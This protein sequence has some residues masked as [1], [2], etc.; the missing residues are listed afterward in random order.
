M[1]KSERRQRDF[2][3]Q[4]GFDLSNGFYQ[5]D[6]DWWAAKEPVEYKRI[7]IEGALD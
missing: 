2:L 5:E 4:C 1:S 6:V 3:D 7:V